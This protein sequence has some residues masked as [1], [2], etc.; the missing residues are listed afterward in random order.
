M[1]SY[2]FIQI[3]F[4]KKINLIISFF[5]I[6]NIYDIDAQR[7]LSTGERL[8]IMDVFRGDSEGY[9]V[10]KHV[11]ILH[12]S[13]T[14]GELGIDTIQDL[15]RFADGASLVHPVREGLVFKSHDGTLNFKCSSNKFLERNRRRVDRS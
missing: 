2:F 12:D 14:L 1:Y 11:P 10:L 8:E 9:S 7:Y 4:H 5:Y 15:L 3:I 13:T 6:F